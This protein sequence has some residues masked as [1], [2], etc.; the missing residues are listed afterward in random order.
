LNRL[1]FSLLLLL[2]ASPADAQPQVTVTQAEDGL[3]SV[4]ADDQVAAPMDVVW[5]TL[6]DY[7]HLASFIPDMQTSRVIS[8]PGEPLHVRQEGATRFIGYNFP[9]NVT[10]EIDTDPPNKVQFHSIVGNVR[11][12]EGSYRLDMSDGV[13]HLHYEARFRPD[14]WVPALI[15][16]SIMH[17]E[18]NRQF[19]GLAAEILRR[20][21]M[22]NRTETPEK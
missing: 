15:G 4:V 6:T 11:D 22:R 16:P 17:G 13:T 8:A 18:I 7:E 19:E 5:Q 3:I 12:M 1:V 10:F 20:N 21:E 14:F 9:I 2:L